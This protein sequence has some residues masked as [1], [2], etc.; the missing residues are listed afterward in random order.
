VRLLWLGL[1]YCYLSCR[2]IL[3]AITHMAFPVRET[4]QQ[5]LLPLGLLT[6]ELTIAGSLDVPCGL[7]DGVLLHYVV[8]HLFYFLYT[9]AWEVA[10]CM[11]IPIFALPS[12]K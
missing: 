1:L 3:C 2:M 6:G 5:M 11:N 4:V 7:T 9:A 8:Y 10:T 12:S